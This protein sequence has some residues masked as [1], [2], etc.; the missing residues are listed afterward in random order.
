MV[1]IYKYADTI[2]LKAGVRKVSL[3]D[4]YKRR[5]PGVEPLRLRS[6]VNELF[7]R[8]RSAPGSRS[9]KAMMQEED[10]QVGRFKVRSLMRELALVSKQ[11]GSHA[12]KKGHSG[13]ARYSE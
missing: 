13:A 8:G 5:T 11:P 10:E 9:I 3:P 1:S 12:Y 2:A 7:T 4:A 6:R